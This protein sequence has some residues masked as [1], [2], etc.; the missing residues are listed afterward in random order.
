MR[1]L[2]P[3]GR[4]AMQVR[5]TASA[6]PAAGLRTVGVGSYALLDSDATMMCETARGPVT[7]T[8]PRAA[9][10]AGRQVSIRKSDAGQDLVKIRSENGEPV[11]DATWLSLAAQNEFVQLQSDGSEWRVVIH[12]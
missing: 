10:C 3:A 7:V 1:I 12:F 9:T 4:D 6:I 5:S 11:G 8:L 2:D